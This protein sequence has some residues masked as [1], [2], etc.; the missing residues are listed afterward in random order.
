MAKQDLDL[1]VVA[2]DNT[3]DTLRAGGQKIN[4]NFIEIYNALATDGTNIDFNIN[5]L[6]LDTLNDVDLT[7]T[8]P[9]NEQYLQFNGVKWVPVTHEVDG[10]VTGHLVPDANVTWDLGSSTHRFRDLYLSSSTLHLGNLAISAGPNGIEQKNVLGVYDCMVDYN[11]MGGVVYANSSILVTSA[12][13]PSQPNPYNSG[14]AEPAY[15]GLNINTRNPIIPEDGIKYTISYLTANGEAKTFSTIKSDKD[16]VSNPPK[17]TDKADE[18]FMSFGSLSSLVVYNKEPLTPGVADELRTASQVVLTITK[19]FVPAE[20]EVSSEVL[21]ESDVVVDTSDISLFSYSETP[22]ATANGNWYFDFL[23]SYETTE[24]GGVSKEH[25]PGLDTSLFTDAED[26]TTNFIDNYAGFQPGIDA[27]IKITKPTGEIVTYGPI[28]DHRKTE[29]GISG[30]VVTGYKT[31]RLEGDAATDYASGTNFSFE[32][33]QISEDNQVT[34]SLIPTADVLYD[35]GS[36]SRRF[37]DLYISGNSIHFGTQKI[38]DEG[39]QIKFSAPLAPFEAETEVFFTTDQFV[40][41]HPRQ[42]TFNEEL[43]GAIVDVLNMKTTLDPEYN[44]NLK[45][46]VAQGPTTLYNELNVKAD[47]LL[48]ATSKAVI[49]QEDEIEFVNQPGNQ[50]DG[51]VSANLRNPEHRYIGLRKGYYA[52][53]KLTLSEGPN[54]LVGTSDTM[55]NM[56]PESHYQFSNST[57]PTLGIVQFVDGWPDEIDGL[58]HKLDDNIESERQEKFR[59]RKLYQP[60]L[61]IKKAG[62]REIIE[63]PRRSGFRYNIDQEVYS[64]GDFFYDFLDKEN[65]TTTSIWVYPLVRKSDNTIVEGKNYGQ[66]IKDIRDSGELTWVDDNNVTRPSIWIEWYKISQSEETLVSVYHPTTKDKPVEHSDYFQFTSKNR[67]KLV[68]GTRSDG[69]A[70]DFVKQA[71]EDRTK[72]LNLILTINRQDRVEYNLTP[73]GRVYDATKSV[74]ANYPD[75]AGSNTFVVVNSRVISLLNPDIYNNYKQSYLA[76]RPHLWFDPKKASL[77][78]SVT[79]TDPTKKGEVLT[80]EGEQNLENK[81]LGKE[82]SPT[83]IDGH[84]I[85]TENIAYDLG[86]P[87]NRFRDLYLSSDSFHLGGTKLSTSG[88]SLKALDTVYSA[89]WSAG[90]GGLIQQMSYTGKE[91]LQYQIIKNTQSPVHPGPLEDNG[92]GTLRLASGYEAKLKV[93][94]RESIQVAKEYPSLEGTID[95]DKYERM[96]RQSP[97]FEQLNWETSQGHQN[98]I[99]HAWVFSDY[100][101]DFEIN[102]YEVEVD[103][104]QNP[105]RWKIV[106]KFTKE[107]PNGNEEETSEWF[108]RK[109]S[110]SGTTEWIWEATPNTKMF[111]VNMFAEYNTSVNYYDIHGNSAG[112]DFEVMVDARNDVTYIQNEGQLANYSLPLTQITSDGNTTPFYGATLGM[113][114]L[115]AANKQMA[116]GATHY[117]FNLDLS[118]TIAPYHPGFPYNPKKLEIVIEQGQRTFLR[119]YAL[120]EPTD[121]LNAIDYVSTYN[122]DTSNPNYDAMS[123]LQNQYFLTEFEILNAG[124][125]NMDLVATEWTRPIHTQALSWVENIGF[126]QFGSTSFGSDSKLMLDANGHEVDCNSKIDLDWHDAMYEFMTNKYGYVQIHI[127]ANHPMGPLTQTT[128]LRLP[129][130]M[131]SKTQKVTAPSK[132]TINRLV[133]PSLSTANTFLW[134]KITEMP[135]INTAIYPHQLQVDGKYGIRFDDRYEFQVRLYND[136]TALDNDKPN[137]VYKQ[138]SKEFYHFEMT[139]GPEHLPK[140]YQTEGVIIDGIGGLVL[141]ASDSNV[142]LQDFEKATSIRLA[143]VAKPGTRD[144]KNFSTNLQND[145][146][147]GKPVLVFNTVDRIQAFDGQSIAEN[148]DIATIINQADSY[149]LEISKEIVDPSVTNVQTSLNAT[150][151]TLNASI[152]NTTNQLNASI[153]NSNQAIANT[154]NQLNQTTTALATTQSELLKALKIQTGMSVPTSNTAPGTMGDMVIDGDVV[155]IAVADDKWGRITLDFNF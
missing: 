131:L 12:T 135:S 95:L 38:S 112:S 22:I 120:K 78:F 128:V 11:P 149:S 82:G 46:R 7:T 3:G 26:S 71:Y 114:Q 153:A 45:L 51:V 87:E 52:N 17:D 146:D 1:G 42:I 79:K 137:K 33:K 37:R 62:T 100:G 141:K 27:K 75:Q 129:N 134:Y 56:R 132:V 67:I 6:G 102:V 92:D 35:L 73:A 155:Y 142:I 16:Y 28:P 104:N 24:I 99:D 13:L 121:S 140:D 25:I 29:A 91:K 136:Q 94:I 122:G 32:I 76:R 15:P 147:D 90:T 74:S 70:L 39:G 53:L 64:G 60:A 69:K 103:N 72:E 96:F 109:E 119:Y 19:E 107:Y 154:Q 126:S 57:D 88:G 150:A 20:P 118:G 21:E 41:T 144:Y 93:N 98:V 59:L 31:I 8:A 80:S 40:S 43:P 145:L 101:N 108:I 50:I 77:E 44:Y 10:R 97:K 123:R 143:L 36:P 65:R 116:A 151:N 14:I 55:N 127:P 9:T 133:D 81:T 124:Q 4:Q 83:Y 18:D 105:T 54:Q 66:Y 89:N 85:P 23:N 115:Y 47:R 125:P 86:S 113:A 63:I 111:S 5:T 117:K 152:A 30:F 58:D 34:G 138:L 84:F 130:I 110:I 49:A 68:K 61:F 106:Y 148:C 2:N 48:S 139:G